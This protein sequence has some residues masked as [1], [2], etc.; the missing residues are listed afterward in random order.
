MQRVHVAR[1]GSKKEEKNE[2]DAPPALPSY[3]EDLSPSVGAKTSLERW[4]ERG[5]REEDGAAKRE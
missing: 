3:S 4:Q 2:T 1:E 5:K